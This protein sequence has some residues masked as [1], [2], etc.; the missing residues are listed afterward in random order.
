MHRLV[1]ESFAPSP[2]TLTAI[3]WATTIIAF[4]A[5][6]RIVRPSFE[7]SLLI[8]VLFF[9]VVVGGSFRVGAFVFGF[10]GIGL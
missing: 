6:I 8:A 3:S 5:V 7:R 9:A 10:W 4:T 2:N 1:L